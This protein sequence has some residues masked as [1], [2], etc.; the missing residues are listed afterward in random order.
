MKRF[1]LI[2]ALSSFMAVNGQTKTKKRVGGFGYFNS[3]YMYAGTT[4]V[5]AL[6][7]NNPNI[8]VHNALFGGGGFLL[9][10]RLVLGGNGFG[11]FG[12]NIPGDIDGEQLALLHGGGGFE[13]GLEWL[14]KK[15]AFLISTF[16]IGGTGHT[17]ERIKGNDMSQ[18]EYLAGGAHFGFNSMF[19]HLLQSKKDD[20]AGG[21]A[22]GLK[23][24]VLF[25]FNDNEWKKEDQ[26]STGTQYKP[27]MFHI[28]LTIG[29]GGYSLR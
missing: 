28:G 6:L 4:G 11:A 12:E 3:G 17:L 21:F 8:P 9:L 14:N 22:L 1:F 24:M 26:T 23:M 7:T 13:V 5:N 18:V 10:N 29:G 25:K 16:H 19:I 2:L 20:D 15:T 27:L